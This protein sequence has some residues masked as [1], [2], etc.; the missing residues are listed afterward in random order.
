MDDEGDDGYVYHDP[1]GHKIFSVYTKM[2]GADAAAWR[3]HLLG[4][5]NLRHYN[6]VMQVHGAVRELIQER[7]GQF[8]G[9]QSYFW[10]IREFRN[11]WEYLGSDVL[12]WPWDRFFQEADGAMESTYPPDHLL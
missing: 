10:Y 5:L 3:D 4:T 9:D 8:E 12:T 6:S 1:D 7:I 11:E 2:E